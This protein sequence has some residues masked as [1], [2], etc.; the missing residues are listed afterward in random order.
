MFGLAKVSL[1]RP[2]GM[3]YADLA[4]VLLTAVS[5]IVAVFGVLMALLALWGYRHFKDVAKSASESMAMKVA[6]D[7]VE[8][9]MREGTAG[10]LIDQ[11]V[12]EAM[13][14]ADG[15]RYEAWKESREEERQKF[16]DLEQS[17]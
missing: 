4:A 15:G 7:E 11:K 1:L 6:R 13:E 3:T 14:S 12:F 10:R 2:I 5:V 9:E 17:D 16:G 8:R